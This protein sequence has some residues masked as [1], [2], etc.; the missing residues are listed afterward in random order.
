MS[1]L[2]KDPQVEQI[3]VQK[4]VANEKVPPPIPNKP[5]STRK[6]QKSSK[7]KERT[8][9]EPK[10][11]EPKAYKAR[12]P[13]EYKC[14]PTVDKNFYHADQYVPVGVYKIEVSLLLMKAN[15]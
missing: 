14:D 6:R 11:P 3:V 1:I 8:F 5:P 7:K 12:V 2:I 15:I 4:P 13:S 9:S 10:V